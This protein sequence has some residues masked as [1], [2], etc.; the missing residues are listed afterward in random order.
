MPALVAFASVAR[1]LHFARAAAELEISPTAVSKTIK[2]LEAQMGARL[3]NRTTRSVSLTEQGLALNDALAPA[4]EQIRRSVERVGD[5]ARPRGALR[6]NTSFVAYASLIEPHLAGFLDSYPDITVEI[7][8]A[9]PLS[10]IVGE[11]FDAGIR[12]GHAL[13]RDMVAVPIG[14]VQRRVVV[15]TPRYL[16]RAGTPSSPEDLLGHDCIRQRLPGRRRFFDWTFRSGRKTVTVDVRGRLVF[17]EMR[18]VLSAA[19]RGAGLAYVFE[20]LASAELRSGSLV[21]VLGEHSPPTESFYV[22]YPHRAHMPGKLRAFLDFM[23]E[24]A[25]RAR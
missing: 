22:Y 20:Q 21:T 6:L 5:A 10:D 9:E 3:F 7:A 2:K 8:I 1:H 12:L 18:S 15:G 11:G 17:D 25:S 19:R 24:A 14:P 16:A 13:Q 23:R 4:L